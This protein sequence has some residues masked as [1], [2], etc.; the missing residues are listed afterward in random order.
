MLRLYHVLLG[1]LVV[2]VLTPLGLIQALSKFSVNRKSVQ[3]PVVQ[4]SAANSQPTQGN[5]WKTILGKTSAPSGWSVSPCEGTAPLLCI[6]SQEKVLG[7]VEMG[8]YALD[9]LPNFQKM[10]LQAGIPENSKIDYQEEKNQNQVT[11]ALKLWTSDQYSILA[12]DRQGEYGNK[13]TF[14]S[15][16]P[17]TVQVGPLKGVYYGFA[18]L[19]KQGGSHEEHRGFVAF[20]GKTLYVITTSF[21]T[22]STTGKFENLENFRNFEPHLPVIVQGVNLIK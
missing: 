6:S 9:K 11:S 5:I 17:Q 1:A 8:V 20:D 18:G 19:K 15:Q 7:T 3:P 4:A 10:L 21:D 14:S 13:I 16:S 2:S 12:K 22:A